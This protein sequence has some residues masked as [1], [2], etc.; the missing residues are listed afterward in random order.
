MNFD[1]KKMELENMMKL[2]YVDRQKMFTGLAR[3]PALDVVSHGNYH[4]HPGKH[5][6]TGI[7][8]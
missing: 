3:N 5:L 4:T 7:V 1:K 8:T 2:Q 6:L